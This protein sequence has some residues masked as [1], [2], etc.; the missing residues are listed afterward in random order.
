MDTHTH[1]GFTAQGHALSIGFA[2]RMRHTAIIGATGA[3]KSVLAR[4]I[5]AQDITRGDG[6][7]LIDPHGDL[8]HAVLSDIGDARKNQVCYLDCA[9]AEFPVGLNLLSA[10]DPD[11]RARAVDGVVAAFRAIFISSWG[12]RL[13]NTLRHALMA[14]IEIPNASLALVPRL[15]VDDEW[16]MRVVPK[17]QNYEA[18]FFFGDRFAKWREDYR[19]QVIDPILNKLEGGFLSFPSIKNII[20]QGRSTLSF[21]QAMNS[22]RIVIVNAATGILG[23]TPARLMGALILAHVRSVAMARARLAPEDRVPF[24][25]VIDEAQ[26]FGTGAIA[27]MMGEVRKYNTSLTIITQYLDAVSETVRSAIL[28]NVATLAVF[29]SN[30]EDAI[31][32]AKK[33]DRTHQRFNTTALQELEDGHA[34]IASSRHESTRIAVSPPPPVGDITAVLKQS[35]RHYGV[36]RSLVEERLARA[37]GQRR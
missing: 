9:E 36:A 34:F 31:L 11:D 5:I 18:R 7:L 10:S 21:E 30:P 25:I 32:L 33:L 19:D 22:K 24:H 15:L 16:R 6:L 3:G 14:L 37:L 17:I 4:H 26:T 27:A 23:E 35:R 20:G 29:R 28:G 12:Y 8:A 13:E 2:E 1:L